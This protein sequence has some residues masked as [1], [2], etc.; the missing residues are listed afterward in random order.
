MARSVRI[1]FPIPSLEEFGKSLGL[2]KIRQK[3]LARIVTGQ[4]N[5]ARVPAHKRT[6]LS[7]GTARETKG[8]MADSRS[9]RN[10]SGKS[11][12]AKAQSH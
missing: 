8:K 7:T 9:S 2:S 4:A 1:S 10:R 5:G 6:R 11:A 3:A 12:K